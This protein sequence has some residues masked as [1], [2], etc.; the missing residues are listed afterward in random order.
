MVV[1]T[2]RITM[3]YQAL[4]KVFLI[5]SVCLK[6]SYTCPPLSR[7]SDTS[8]FFG[9]HQH[10]TFLR[11]RSPWELLKTEKIVHC[12]DTARKGRS[13]DETFHSGWRIGLRP[14]DIAGIA[15]LCVACGTSVSRH[16]A[17]RQQCHSRQARRTG[18]SLRL[19]PRSR[20]PLRLVAWTSSRLALNSHPANGMRPPHRRPFSF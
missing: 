8:D 16:F 10:R 14:S 18:P 2:H 15:G 19:E 12:R 6:N 1:Q 9:S 20:S 3:I 17:V 13:F 11:D 5:C 7:T 4:A